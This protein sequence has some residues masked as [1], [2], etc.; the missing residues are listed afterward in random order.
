MAYFNLT[1]NRRNKIENFNDINY[2]LTKRFKTRRSPPNSHF[3]EDLEAKIWNL[4]NKL[5]LKNYPNHNNLL[6]RK[7]N[8]K[9]KYL[10][11]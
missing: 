9:I 2:E 1:N 5:E 4:L 7:P 6:L 3:L 11:N 10:K 8:E